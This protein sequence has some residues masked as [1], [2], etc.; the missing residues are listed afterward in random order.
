MTQSGTISDTAIWKVRLEEIN[1]AIRIAGLNE[2]IENAKD[3]ALTLIGDRGTHCRLVKERIA[4][5]R[6]I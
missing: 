4:I 1:Q 3:G 6:A 5:A 2:F